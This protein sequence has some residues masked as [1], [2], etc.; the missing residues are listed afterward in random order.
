MELEYRGK[1]FFFEDSP[2]LP[3]LVSEIFEDNYKIFEKNI[4][5]PDGSVIFDI[6]ANEGLFSIML[7]KLYPGAKVYSVEAVP[8]TYFQLL[9]NIGLNGVTNVRPINIG[10]GGQEGKQSFVVANEFSGGSSGVQQNFDAELN[11][12]EDISVTTLDKIYEMV[13][14]EMIRLLKIDIEGM[15]Y[16]ALY[17]FK[18]L[19]KVA[20][21][22]HINEH[23]KSK[24][25]DIKELAT[26]VGSK[27]NLFFYQPCQM[28]E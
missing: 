26:Y 22:F 5:F 23:L 8:R 3:H 15:E 20:G 9:R 7:G 6:G 24:Q 14:V 19:D 11:H 2:T 4:S 27:A 28:A 12:Q 16:E 21:E 25:Y 18:N 10:V 1:K 13:G 17:N